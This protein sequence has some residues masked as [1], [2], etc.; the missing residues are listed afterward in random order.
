MTPVY[1]RS[2]AEFRKWLEKN[3]KTETELLVG[4]YKVGSDRF[5]MTWSQ[6]VDEALCYGWIDGIRRSVDN[7]RYCIRFT[8]RNPT[9]RWS[10]VNIKKVEELLQKGLMKQPG[11][12]AFNSRRDEKS[13]KYSYENKPAKLPH[14][15][16]KLFKAN[17]Q[18]WRFFSG[19]SPSY[20]RTIFFWIMSAKQEKTQLSRLNK[21]IKESEKQNR[22]M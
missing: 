8:P 16:E 14:R 10:K 17:K 5:N 18:A 12:E 1:F 11:I 22:V 2:Q 3:H 13:I 7:E 9:S 15:L 6:S 19:L 21:T 20:Q 4:F